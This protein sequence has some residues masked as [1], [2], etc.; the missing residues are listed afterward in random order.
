MLIIHCKVMDKK[1]ARVSPINSK[2]SPK[3]KIKIKNV[4]TL[5]I[6]EIRIGLVISRPKMLVSII[7]EIRTGNV[8]KLIICIGKIT[9]L[10]SGAYNGIII[11]ESITAN[12]INNNERA[13]EKTLSFLL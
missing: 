12:K 6:L 4:K 13:T 1:R 9:S 5:T 10:Y 7:V 8:V 3:S 11:G 2:D